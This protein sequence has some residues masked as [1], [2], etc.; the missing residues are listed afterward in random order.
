MTRCDEMHM[1]EHHAE[2]RRRQRAAYLWVITVF[3]VLIYLAVFH[4]AA[5]AEPIKPTRDEAVVKVKLVLGTRKE[6]QDECARFGIILGSEGG[7]AVFRRS[8]EGAS[9]TAYAPKPHGTDDG[10]R[11]A[12][13]GHEVLHCFKGEYHDHP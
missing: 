12:L 13:V 1:R 5:S 6:I 7:C 2:I 11:M 3:I 10:E 4:S 8:E 9:C